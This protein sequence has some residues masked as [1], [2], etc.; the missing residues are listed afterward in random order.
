VEAKVLAPACGGLTACKDHG[1]TDSDAGLCVEVTYRVAAQDTAASLGSGDVPSLATPCALAMLEAATVRI[2]ESLVEPGQTSVGVEVHLQHWV[3]T[4]VGRDVHARAKLTRTEC[5]RLYFQVELTDSDRV[6]A[7][8]QVVRAV[9][10][11][12]RFIAGLDQS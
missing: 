4:P 9:V 1:V 6:V 10:D 3:A 2:V 5:R 12:A 11:R 8:G 7:S